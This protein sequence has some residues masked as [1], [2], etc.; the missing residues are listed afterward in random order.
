MFAHAHA[1][2]PTHT[3]THTHTHTHTHNHNRRA[4]AALVVSPQPARVWE[5]VREFAR[6][7]SVI[8][9]AAKDAVEIACGSFLFAA[10]T[11]Y[12]LRRQDSHREDRARARE[13]ATRA[14]TS[15][16]FMRSNALVVLGRLQAGLRAL[17]ESDYVRA[18]RDMRAAV[19]HFPEF[20]RLRAELVG[21]AFA[22]FAWVEAPRT[23]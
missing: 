19:F 13:V 12:V 3:P 21:M 20:A 10:T 17:S 4:E 1:H 7:R 5:A 9:R 22:A 2:T 14:I 15:P 18:F 23:P 11:E 16:G 8:G 6:A